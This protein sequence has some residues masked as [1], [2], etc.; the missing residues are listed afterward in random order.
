VEQDCLVEFFFPGK[1]ADKREYPVIRVDD[2]K[3]MIGVSEFEEH[4]SQH[5]VTT[6]FCSE[7]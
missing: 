1:P 3:R 6:D 5:I 2:D 7:P 4:R